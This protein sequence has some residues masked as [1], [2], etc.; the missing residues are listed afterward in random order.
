MVKNAPVGEIPFT[1][2]GD[3]RIYVTAFVNGSDSL[4]FLVDTGASLIV[5]N[6]NSPKLK[7]FIHNGQTASILGTT[8]EKDYSSSDPLPS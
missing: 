4:R 6:T 8:G 3:S 2:D 5:L 7:G 1:I